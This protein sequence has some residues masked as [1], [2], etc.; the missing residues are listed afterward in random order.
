V[1]PYSESN[2]PY[3]Q[4]YQNAIQ[5]LMEKDLEIS[6]LRAL[7]AKN[8]NK[9]KEEEEELVVEVVADPVFVPP[10]SAYGAPPEVFASLINPTPP[11]IQSWKKGRLDWHDL[12]PEH[13]SFMSQYG[14]S[15]SENFDFMKV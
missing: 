10:T 7:V 9:L 11:V 15:T 13:D 12:I 5:T 2:D 3:F 6:Q 1:E 4:K 14:P 8:D